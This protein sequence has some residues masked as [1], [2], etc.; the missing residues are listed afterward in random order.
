MVPQKYKVVYT[1]N[2]YLI[3]GKYYFATSFCIWNKIY[4]FLSVYVLSV[5]IETRVKWR[6]YQF[7]HG[8]GCAF[9]CHSQI[10]DFYWFTCSS[11]K[12]LNN[13][14]PTVA[15]YCNITRMTV[16]IADKAA[17]TMCCV[18]RFISP[19]VNQLQTSSKKQW[20][21]LGFA[22]LLCSFEAYH[23]TTSLQINMNFSNRKSPSSVCSDTCRFAVTA[24]FPLESAAR[25]E[26]SFSYL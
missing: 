18:L 5:T 15:R 22:Y 20:I 10:Y 24:L 16:K 21:A 6:I 1:V 17:K 26:L 9:L 23:W 3:Q 12:N 4:K 13:S 14:L 8:A 19:A 11:W 7:V 2:R 25:L